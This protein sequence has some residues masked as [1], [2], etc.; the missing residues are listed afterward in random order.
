MTSAVN[1]TIQ[2]VEADTLREVEDA[3][4]VTTQK[5][6]TDP[7]LP[8][9][10]LLKF[11]AKATCDGEPAQVSVQYYYFTPP[12]FINLSGYRP[13][14]NVGP[15]PNF[16][17][18]WPGPQNPVTFFSWGTPGTSQTVRVVATAF[19]PQCGTRDA[20]GSAGFTVAP[21]VK[22]KLDFWNDVTLGEHL[23]TE[24]LE[25]SFG[26]V[27]VDAGFKFRS[28]KTFAQKGYFGMIELF[29]GVQQF[30]LDN[31]PADQW[32]SVT[33]EQSYVLD[34][35]RGQTDPIS[36][37]VNIEPNVPVALRF[38]DSPSISIQGLIKNPRTQT[39]SGVQQRCSFQCYFL[40]NASTSAEP[41]EDFNC[42]WYPIGQV[43]EWEIYGQ[44]VWDPASGKRDQAHA[45]LV[46]EVSRPV[47]RALPLSFPMWFGNILLR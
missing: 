42:M 5:S 32:E 14:L 38:D 20:S 18:D 31:W 10:R 13:S 28:T 43:I 17:T 8:A 22:E 4:D 34:V 37:R 29:K 24:D 7:I 21:L 1:H 44:A 12:P 45:W 19:H 3:E 47:K 39:V 36:Q 23:V 2:L 33:N 30:R 11:T 46:R 40:F 27:Y 25:F 15:P 16:I 26:K 35:P 41:N 9:G 6:L